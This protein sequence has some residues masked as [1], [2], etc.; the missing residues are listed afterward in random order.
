VGQL[1]AGMAHDFNNLLAS[2]LG[3]LELLDLRLTDE[4]QRKLLQAAIRSVQR[5]AKLNEQV[6]AFSRKQ[7]LAPKSVDLNALIA[8]I[9]DMLRR[10]LGGTAEVATALAPD[11]WPALV[12]PHQFELVILNLAINARDAMPLGGRVVIETRAIKASELEA[13]LDLTPGDYLRVAVCDTGTGMS[14]DV[15]ARAF[16]PFFT[17][18]EV[19]KGSGLGLAQVYGFARQSGGGVRIR[20]AV[21][22]GTTVEIYLPRSFGKPE[23]PAES[24]GGEQPGA[25]GRATILVVDDQE[26][27]REVAAGQ[28]EALGYRVVQ[29]TSGETALD[30][31]K[32]RA[33][34]D[35]LM[36]DY[37][38]PGM[39]GTELAR[40]ALASRPDLPVLLVTGYADT[41]P[42]E[43][44][45]PHARLLKKPY[46]MAELSAAID[47]LLRPRRERKNAATNI[48]RLRAAEE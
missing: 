28:L 42:M 30:L 44:E 3:N 2:I 36:A 5:G 47:D 21:G 45:V 23:A 34:V 40:S 46:R 26:D 18:K 24:A 48:F 25:A 16:E 22:K 1:A 37:A 10:T 6:L 17:T 14:E 39:S 32:G 4:R 38:M 12:D 20:S 8:E 35:L 27:V 33:G 15:L 43:G 31:L 19:G 41:T 9:E 13:S 29:A 7:H 11:L